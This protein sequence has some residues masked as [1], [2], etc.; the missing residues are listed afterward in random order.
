M[1]STDCTLAVVDGTRANLKLRLSVK[2]D[3]QNYF[4]IFIL[5]QRKNEGELTNNEANIV[6]TN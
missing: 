6:S 3:G 5:R 4:W 2:F 1:Y